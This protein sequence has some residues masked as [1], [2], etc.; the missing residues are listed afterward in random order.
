MIEY[1]CAAIRISTRLSIAGY[2]LQEEEIGL[3]LL[4]EYYAPCEGEL[5]SAVRNL[6]A[7]HPLNLINPCIGID[8]TI[9][10]N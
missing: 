1:N 4:L 9:C 3:Y 10:Q 6:C 8:G 7:P 5:T 2:L